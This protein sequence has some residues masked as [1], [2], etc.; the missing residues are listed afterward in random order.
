MITLIGLSFVVWV[1]QTRQNFA[2]GVQSESSLIVYWRLSTAIRSACSPVN[3]SCPRQTKDL[4]QR[5]LHAAAAVLLQLNFRRLLP[6]RCRLAPLH[7]HNVWRLNV[8]PTS[9][10]IIA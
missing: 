5:I 8:G 3:W 10:R 6:R 1:R 2:T 4:R 9:T 7:P